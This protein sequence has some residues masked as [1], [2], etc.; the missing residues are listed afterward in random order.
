[1]RVGGMV[2]DEG[3]GE[4]RVGQLASLGSPAALVSARGLSPCADC[5]VEAGETEELAE[6]G[7]ADPA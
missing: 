4:V 3:S 1:V 2:F 5:G 6:L 7:R